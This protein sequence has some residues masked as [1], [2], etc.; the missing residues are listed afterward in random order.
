M[1]NIYNCTPYKIDI[2]DI[3]GSEGIYLFDKKGKK[4]MDLE[5]GVWCTSVGHNNEQLNDVIKKQISLI[6]HAGF[7]YSGTIVEE[8]AE[9]ILKITG[10]ENGKCVF[11]CSGSEAIELARQ[12]SK[13]VTGKKISMT[14]HDSYLGSYSSVTDRSENWYIF[15]WEKCKSCKF[16]RNCR[17][18]CEQFENIPEN[19]SDFIFEPGSSSGFVRFPPE[20]LI[21]N[22][23]KI[24]K[25][26][27]GK[28]ILN[29]VTTGIGRT[30]RWFG[31][32]HY[33]IKADMIA[34]GKGVGNGYPVSV[35]VLN[36]ETADQSAKAG[37]KYMQSHQNDPLGASIVKEVINII[38]SDDMVAEAERKGE[39]FLQQLMDL[40]KNKIIIGVRGRG[41]L[42]AVDIC[43]KKTG[44][45]IYKK[46]LDKGFIICNR[47]ALFRIDPPLTIREEEFDLFIKAF[48]NILD[49]I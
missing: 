14:M 26:N 43:D 27:G 19:L 45:Y 46:L 28:I 36:K 38:D 3:T 23:V 1:S 39:L 24:V 25:T 8:S 15:N 47:G 18:D 9:S 33:G 34:I 22:I 37:F 44:N 7:S 20:S 49:S 13:K 12:I 42:F 40:Q 5:S 32:N 17:I 21:L 2:P 6:M 35:T 10:L 11:L 48:N 4:Y 29:E 41:L 31:F 16:K 30:G